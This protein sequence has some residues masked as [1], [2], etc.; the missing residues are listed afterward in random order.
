MKT[1]SVVNVTVFFATKVKWAQKVEKVIN[2]KVK[3][4]YEFISVSF[5]LWGAFITFCK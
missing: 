3:E 2:E 5:T 4:G 1:Y